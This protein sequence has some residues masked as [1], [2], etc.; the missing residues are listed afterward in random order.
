MAQNL[1]YPLVA[2]L[3]E[4]KDERSLDS[5]P[6]LRTARNV[7]V[8]R[9]KEGQ[10]SPR[11][12][13]VAMG[14][15][16][17]ECPQAVFEHEAQLYS[18][19][20]DL[21]S[22]YDGEDWQDVCPLPQHR[23]SE[24][25]TIFGSDPRRGLGN[26]EFSG[27]AHAAV[28]E[29]NGLRV[30][31]YHLARYTYNGTGEVRAR[32][33][34]GGY[35]REEVIA[36]L[37][38]IAFDHPKPI[39]RAVGMSDS[40]HVFWHLRDSTDY[41][42]RRVIIDSDGTVG[43]AADVVSSTFSSQ[44]VASSVGQNWDICKHPSADEYFLA[45][46][47]NNSESIRGIRYGADGVPLGIAT[48]TVNNADKFLTC[49]YGNSRYIVATADGSD[50]SLAAFNNII[51]ESVTTYATSV[52]GCDL[53]GITSTRGENGKA[54]VFLNYAD[55]SRS[56]GCRIFEVLYTFP[57]SAWSVVFYPGQGGLARLFNFHAVSRPTPRGDSIYFLAS[58]GSAITPMNPGAGLS[59]VRMKTDLSRFGSNLGIL[60][61]TPEIL[62]NQG[63]LLGYEGQTPVDV[64]ASQASLTF[65]IIRALQTPDAASP[66]SLA[67][68]GLH[69]ATATTDRRIHSQASLGGWQYTAGGMLCGFD[70]Q[71]SYEV[72]YSHTPAEP[73]ISEGGVGSLPEASY[74][75][76]WAYEWC[77]SKGN[78][79]RGPVQ[80]ASFQ[81]STDNKTLL[82]KFEANTTPITFKAF[83]AS[84]PQATLKLVTFLS[85]PNGSVL[86]RSFSTALP[87]SG[88]GT[89]SVE[90][91]Y[92]DTA[93]EVCPFT[94][95]GQGELQPFPPPP[96][97]V[98]RAHQG[99]LYL[100]PDNDPARVWYSKEPVD[101]IAPEFNPELSFY[102]GERVVSLASSGGNLIVFGEE[103]IYALSVLPANK[104]GE[105]A[106]ANLPQL[107]TAGCGC[108]D[109]RATVETPLGVFFL[110]PRGLCILPKG[111]VDPVHIG[112]PIERTLEEYP[113]IVGA[114]HIPEQECVAFAAV[115]DEDAGSEAKGVVL[116]Y[117]Y[118]VNQWFEWDYGQAVFTLGAGKLGV[119]D[120][121]ANAPVLTKSE[122]PGAMDCTVETED[123]RVGGAAGMARVRRATLLG[124][125]LGDCEVK[126]SES[127][128]S[129]ATYA[130]GST[131]ELD[132]AG[133]GEF[134]LE[135]TLKQQKTNRVR[136]KISC[137]SEDGGAALNALKLELQ[138]IKGAARL[139]PSRRGG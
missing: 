74:L 110:A 13:V 91:L 68:M 79:V 89:V 75:I 77:D 34:G 97:T 3:D 21:L 120:D 83:D 4:S 61:V 82:L 107:V 102:V 14:E 5:T 134:Y 137:S 16:T 100:V 101:N 58:Q 122:T 23:I 37:P 121:S 71:I 90:I 86:Y 6:R 53:L 136:F 133:E 54:L 119:F 92:F 40:V 55:G 1:D 123:I 128:D 135:R 95:A 116:A 69:L 115:D 76:G 124:E 81:T 27:V 114:M 93:T 60:G 35:V 7:T 56:V 19:E 33:E 43:P 94:D 9:G 109:H 88:W 45:Y 117:N 125:R 111:G 66:G 130:T 51:F 118:R 78:S 108:L 18:A 25:K 99:R 15:S 67:G 73:E 12:G 8:L 59:L 44:P 84:R 127:H 131:F 38:R 112:K 96:C 98:I 32:V 104:Y 31:V 129:G 48:T 39:V 62:L 132:D 47:Y 65:P 22:V 42:I 138:P 113:S 50:I 63:D 72:G 85:Q 80:V 139:K 28:A 70:G 52:T 41:Y 36:S 87:R 20:G 105:G 26:A 46:V 64:A 126:I 2:P 49:V 30:T 106:G 17:Q 24:F 103:N 11:P 10:L 57:P 29:I